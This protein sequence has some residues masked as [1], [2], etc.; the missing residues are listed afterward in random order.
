MAAPIKVKV[1]D[2]LDVSYFD[3]AFTHQEVQDDPNNQKD[4]D[5]EKYNGEFDNFYFNPDPESNVNSSKL[6]E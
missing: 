6:S 2:P 5:F 4:A 1:R 3:D